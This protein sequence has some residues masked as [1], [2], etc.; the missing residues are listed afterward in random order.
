MKKIHILE[1]QMLN[2]RQYF[3]DERSGQSYEDNWNFEAGTDHP[4]FEDERT[5]QSYEANWNTEYG[6][7]FG[8]WQ[9]EYNGNDIFSIGD[10]YTT[11]VN[12]CGKMAKRYFYNA[13]KENMEEEISYF[14]DALED[15]VNDFKQYGYTYNEDI[16]MY[17]SSDGSDEIDLDEWL[18]ENCYSL[19]RDKAK[20]ITENAIN[21]GSIPNADE[22][23]EEIA[24][25]EAEYYDFTDKDGID[26]AL[27]EIG[28]S[29][30]GYFE[31][32]RNEGRIWP[33]LGMI[34]FYTTEQPD[35]QTL[36][37]IMRDLANTGIV[38]YEDLLQY[39]MVF[40]DWRNDGEI[41]ACTLSDYIDGNYGPDSYE[42]EEENEIQYARDGKTQFIPHLANQAQKREFFRD[43]RNTRD[44]AVYAPRERA[45][46]NLA[47]YHA[48]R[49]PYG[50]NKQM[51]NN[52]IK[53][54][55]NKLIKGELR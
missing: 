23:A 8:Y 29:F 13:K 20:E 25:N 24:S 52:V 49:Y 11:H 26:Q 28:S 51:I 22:L 42:D 38:T 12:A 5:G 9:E 19:D 7:P 3:E 10:A 35:P 55:L 32:G 27:E 34:G 4:H 30:E 31:S 43:F 21:G 41:T 45:A 2:E 36:T 37:V 18:D 40:E 44:Q 46:G 15:L 17:V 33:Q 54:E 50:E 6:F 16:D 53:E 1:S 14:T 47:R 39:D 48:M